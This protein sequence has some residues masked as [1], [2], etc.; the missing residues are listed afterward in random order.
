MFKGYDENIVAHRMCISP[1]FGYTGHRLDREL[2]HY[3]AKYRYY[4][5]TTMRWLS[6]DPLGMVDGPNVYAYVSG[7][8]V[9]AVDPDGQAIIAIAAGVFVAG[10]L[11]ANSIQSAINSRRCLKCLNDAAE[12]ARKAREKFEGSPH[13]YFEWF[14]NAKPGTECTDICNIA[15]IKVVNTFADTIRPSPSITNLN[16]V[17]VPTR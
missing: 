14:R 6:R 7:S 16:N 8:V 17:T 13:C 12:L 1:T 11:V 9:N 15:G 2:N 10:S 4:N 5:P 3:Y